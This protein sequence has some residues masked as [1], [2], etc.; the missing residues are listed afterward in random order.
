M[1]SSMDPGEICFNLSTYFT[2][3]VKAL[4]GRQVTNTFACEFRWTHDLNDIEASPRN[5]VSK[6]LHLSIR[7]GETC[8]KCIRNQKWRHS[9]T[10]FHLRMSTWRQHCTL[11]LCYPVLT[12][13]WSL[14]YIVRYI[15][16]TDEIHKERKVFYH[17]LSCYCYYPC[18]QTVIIIMKTTTTT[19]I[20][21]S[22]SLS[23]RTPSTTN[24]AKLQCSSS[25]KC[26]IDRVLWAVTHKQIP[27][28]MIIFLQSNLPHCLYCY[29]FREP[30][31]S[32]FY[33]TS[34]RNFLWLFSV[35]WLFL[36]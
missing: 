5:I 25:I 6:H 3:C 19:T 23:H 29:V 4:T 34:V 30:N 16:P 15:L 13:V 10:F 36:F 24:T 14:P 2:V 18:K 35:P 21:E 11:H 27:N 22:L 33:Q 28:S 8:K 26:T 32:N 12:L 1:A 20:N 9:C 17:L 7:M 31:L